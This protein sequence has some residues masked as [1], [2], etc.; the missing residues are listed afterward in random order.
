MTS[1][2][3]SSVRQLCFGAASFPLPY[4]LPRARA[5]VVLTSFHGYGY[6]GSPRVWYEHLLAHHAERVDPVWLSTRAELVARLQ[7]RFGARHAALTHSA[8]GLL[9]LARARA[10]VISHGV[11]DLPYLHVNRK[12]L[13]IQTFHGLPTKRGE[14]LSDHPSLSLRF[15]IWRRWRPVDVFLSSSPLVSRIYGARFG[16]KPETFLELGCPCHDPLVRHKE[17][18]GADGSGL[19]TEALWPGAP[20]HR[21][22]ILY[23]PTYRKRAPTRFFPF[24]DFDGPKL[25]AFLEERQ[26][27]LCLRPHPNDR[28]DLAPLLALSPRLVLA[29]DRQIEDT[30]ELLPKVDLILTDY[31]SIYLEGLL[32]G[33]PSVFI[34]YDREEYERGFPFDYD[35]MTPGP[36]VDRQDALLAA[37]RAALDGTDEAWARRRQEVQRVFFTHG[38]G[39]AAERVSQWLL[40]QLGL[41][42]AE[43]GESAR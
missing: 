34:P 31:S 15:E 9:E 23:A 14:L 40:T 16:L 42:P 38:D 1:G 21:E 33:V 39:Q 29:A 5:K 10:I 19:G 4:L 24:A 12:A 7:G 28:V 27:L 13:L 41:A 20:R 2:I 43:P 37:I 36:K 32:A 11:D 35:E 8:R 25:A 6:R 17:R 18:A 22:V 30:A 3:L 26:A